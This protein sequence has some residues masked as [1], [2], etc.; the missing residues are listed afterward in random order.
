MFGELKDLFNIPVVS[1]VLI[2]IFGAI[3]KVYMQFHRSDFFSR[4]LPERVKA[5]KWLRNSAAPA[6]A[7]LDKAE[8]QLHLQSFGLHRDWELS[9][10]IICFCSEHAQSSIPSLKA[11]LR[12]QGM[13]TINDG[14]IYPH[15]FHKWLVP[16]VLIWLLIFIGAE[17]YRSSSQSDSMQ[18]LTD[19]FVFGVAFIV[20]CWVAVCALKVSSISKKLNAYTPPH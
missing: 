8:Q 13:Y 16:L 14:K 17:I 15:K 6:S 4:P 1:S 19:L 18:I 3:T 5:V 11:I 12:Y 7:P 20:W 9:Y 10:K 2:A